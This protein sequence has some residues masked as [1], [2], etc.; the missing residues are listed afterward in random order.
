MTLQG[1]G[2]FD[3]ESVWY[4]WISQPLAD[5]SRHWYSPSWVMLSTIANSTAKLSIASRGRILLLSCLHLL[6]PTLFPIF[7]YQRATS[8]EARW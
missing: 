7:M 6:V 3:D 4:S 8:E 2:H 5:Q 1:A